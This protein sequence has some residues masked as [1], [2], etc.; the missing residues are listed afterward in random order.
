MDAWSIMLLRLLLMSWTS[1]SM[2]SLATSSS[3][4]SRRST[5]SAFSLSVLATGG[6]CVMELSASQAPP[7][8]D[9]SRGPQAW[10]G[11]H[12]VE[13]EVSDLGA[14]VCAWQLLIRRVL[15]SLQG[16]WTYGISGTAVALTAPSGFV[17]MG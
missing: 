6:C 9:P 3:N 1:P 5:S 16:E 2:A 17:R 15:T 4:R 7:S 14:L 10:I 13:N 11:R 8:G 12:L